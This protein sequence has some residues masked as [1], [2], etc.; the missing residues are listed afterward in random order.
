[1]QKKLLWKAALSAAVLSLAACGR[2]HMV[3]VN[4]MQRE[5]GSQPSVAGAGFT[6]VCGQIPSS[7]D[8][9]KELNAVTATQKP[10]GGTLYVFVPPQRLGSAGCTDALHEAQ[11]QAI[12]RANL[13]DRVFFRKIDTRGQHP[14]IADA[15]YYLWLEGDELVT[16]YKDGPRLALFNGPNRLDDW[17]KNIGRIFDSAKEWAQSKSD[18]MQAHLVGPHIYYMLNGKE[19]GSAADLQPDLEARKAALLRNLHAV[20]AIAERAHVILATPEEQKAGMHQV[21][22]TQRVLSA[23]IG[24]SVFNYFSQNLNGPLDRNTGMDAADGLFAYEHSF[25][26]L[27]AAVVQRSGLFGQVDISYQDV[28][29]PPYAGQDVVLWQ[30]KN[31][32]QWSLR[33]GLGQIRTI[34]WPKP[35]KDHPDDAAD[36]FVRN[37]REAAAAALAE[38]QP[39]NADRLVPGCKLPDYPQTARKDGKTGAVTASFEI[40]V[41]GRVSGSHV[42]ASSGT[43]ELDEAM[44]AAFAQCSFKPTVRN[45]EPAPSKLELRYVW[46][47]AGPNRLPVA[48]PAPAAAPVAQPIS[49][50]ARID[51]SSCAKPSYPPGAREKGEQGVVTLGFSVGADGAVR[52]SRIETSSGFADLDSAALAALS[53]CRFSPA[54]ANGKPIDNAWTTM[55]YAWSLDR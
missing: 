39:Q 28:A 3:N 9:S 35:D 15:D 4:G 26:E 20:P 44:V 40:D 8:F 51:S 24:P 27:K 49:T 2:T 55:N 31:A 16:S 5:T 10:I 48:A 47:L 36:Q 38:P 1:M 14:V 17:V 29:N 13:F 54:M 45:G 25:H 50:P 43:Q 37:V 22:S 34:E 41:A 32:P 46:Q 30:F 18:V 19:Y 52:T 7:S 33:V 21:A 42:V 11:A 53:N 6:A 23:V 12:E